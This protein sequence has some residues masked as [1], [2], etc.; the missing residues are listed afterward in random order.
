MELKIAIET[1]KELEKER[2]KQVEK[3]RVG[4]K[5]YENKNDITDDNS[6]ES[7]ASGE[8]EDDDAVRKHDSRISSPF[9][10]LLV[11]QKQSYT[12]AKAPTIDVGE[13]KTNN[14]IENVLGDR[15]QSILQRL[16]VEASLGGVAWLHV[17][18]DEENVFRYGLVPADQITP[19]YSDTVEKKLLAVRRTYNRF[20]PT[21]GNVYTHDEYWT[22]TEAAYFKRKSDEGYDKL[23]AD[24]RI[25]EVD[26]TTENV[27][28]KSNTFVH[29]LCDV[30]FIKFA[31]NSEETGDLDQYKGQ[32]D[33]YD[34]VMNGFINDVVDVQEVI[35]VLKG[36]GG[37]DL[38]EFMEELKKY[39]SINMDAEEPGTGVETLSIDIP[40]EA[41]NSLMAKLNDDIYMFGQGLD[42][43]KVQLGTSVSGVA[44]KMM[45][46]ALEMKAAKV[47]SEFRGGINR[48]VRFILRDLNKSD[49]VKIT[50]TWKRSLIDN[51]TEVAQ[52]VSQLAS[53]SS[54]EAIAK[55][56]PLVEDW[57]EELQMLKDENNGTDEFDPDKE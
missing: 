28:S 17:W 43:N 38:K 6:G 42:P 19:I 41:R 56:N 53:V 39:K 35:L 3:L 30:P 25:D 49:D 14:A 37:T 57:A 2:K 16:I 11:D 45:Y 54:K 18:N 12:G 51:Q 23:I 55:A 52:V 8:K 46:S 21:D 33:A 47:E 7:K 32:I 13:E 27:V 36:Y 1:F 4:R 9:H 24:E 50:Q 40:V 5:Y 10:H 34:I 48:L 26:M 44:L 31:N 20:D 22:E 15:Y 29:N